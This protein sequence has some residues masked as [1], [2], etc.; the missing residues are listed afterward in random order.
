M[1]I[2]YKNKIGGYT[3]AEMIVAVGIFLILISI[4]AGSFI[5]ILRTQ[6]ETMALLA[7]NS[8]ASLAMEQIS[9]EV[10][11]GG[12]FL[13]SGDELHF[14]N[15]KNEAVIYRVNRDSGKIQRSTDGVNFNDITADNVKVFNLS[16]IVFNGGAG[17][18]YPFRVTVII[19][20]SPNLA[21][22]TSPVI[23]L[24][25]TISARVLSA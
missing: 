16:F 22:F 9:R 20:A 14:T 2:Y 19:Q 10:R 8:N 12:A 5:R 3:I 23:N 21:S 15:S 1:K 6:R 11:T 7:T 25:T 17:D 13:V 18:R 4:A 24:Q